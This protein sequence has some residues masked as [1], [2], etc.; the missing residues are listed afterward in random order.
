MID[1]LSAIPSS[2]SVASA[3]SRY[4]SSGG[5][6]EESHFFHFCPR[7]SAVS[8][9]TVAENIPQKDSANGVGCCLG[10]WII[11]VSGASSL[12]LWIL[13]VYVCMH[14]FGWAD[15]CLITCGWVLQDL[16]VC[17]RR[18]EFSWERWHERQEGEVVARE[19]VLK[20]LNRCF[21][22]HFN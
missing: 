12:C 4:D 20:L 6:K 5:K 16:V 22:N 11:G 2:L 3:H 18:G 19:F 21:L 1:P 17:Q 13:D 7:F 14:G 9:T 15:L 10:G 8:T